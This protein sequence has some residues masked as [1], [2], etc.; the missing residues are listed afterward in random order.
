M[1]VETTR[2]ETRLAQSAEDLLAAQR[3]R[4]RVFVRELGGGGAGVDHAR[5]IESDAFDPHCEHLLLIDRAADGW[6]VVG[7]YRLLDRHGAAQ[8]G[9]YYSEAEYDL[10]CLKR[11]GRRLLEL[12]RSCLDR[13]YRGGAGMMHLWLALSDLVIRRGVELLF[14]VA[15]FHGTDTGALAEPLSQLHRA[16]L[17]PDDIRPRSRAHQRMDLMPGE[18]IDR[19]RAMRAVPALIKAYLRLGGFVGDGA[20]VDHAFNT[21]DVCLVLDTARMNDRQRALYARGPQG[22]R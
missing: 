17:A 4:Y 1:D 13:D 11:S 5:G 19:A 8:A 7:V 6:P 16:H 22:P 9:Q 21:T 20:F 14:G 12:G 2:Y 10:D 3:L 18:S 15:S